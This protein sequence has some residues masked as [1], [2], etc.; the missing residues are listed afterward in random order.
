MSILKQ[1]PFSHPT[2]LAPYHQTS[3]RSFVLHRLGARMRMVV[4]TSGLRADGTL[5]RAARTP[6][7]LAGRPP[8]PAVSTSSPSPLP[9]ANLHLLAAPQLRHRDARIACKRPHYDP[10]PFTGGTLASVLP[11]LEPA[12][13]EKKSAVLV[14]SPL[15]ISNMVSTGVLSNLSHGYNTN[16]RRGSIALLMVCRGSDSSVSVD[17]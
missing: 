16:A 12:L 7:L 11:R 17:C 9:I 1:N 14:I 15:L 10:D 8:W 5:V 2:L 3:R 13:L 4:G 6:R